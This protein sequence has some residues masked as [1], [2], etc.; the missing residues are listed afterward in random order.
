M[1]YSQINLNVY[2]GEEITV[3]DFATLFRE[4]YSKFN[5]LNLSDLKS[6]STGTITVDGLIPMNWCGKQHYSNTNSNGVIAVL[7]KTMDKI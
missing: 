2:D 5:A 7:Q 3:A 4:A 1:R 6:C